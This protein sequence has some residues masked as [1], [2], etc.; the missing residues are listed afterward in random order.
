MKLYFTLTN[1]V[2]NSE[3]HLNMLRL[4]LKSARENT[5]LDL[6]A[7]YDGEIGDNSYNIFKENGVNVILCKC[8]FTDKLKKYYANSR[9]E[10]LLNSVERMLGCFM[11]FDIALYE[12]DDDVVLY[13]DIDTM[14]LKDIPKEAFNVKTLAAAPE[15]DKNFDIIKGNKYFSAGIMM[16][17]IPELTKRREKLFEM[18]DNNIQ[19][20][21]ECWDQGFFNELYKDDF[22]PL[23]LEYNWKPYW[24]IND[25]AIIIHIHGLKLGSMTITEFNLAGGLQNRDKEAVTGLVYY[26]L[27]A[28]RILG[29]NKDK[30]IAQYTKFLTLAQRFNNKKQWLISSF[31]FYLIYKLTANSKI[32]VKIHNTAKKKLL[33]RNLIIEDMNVL[34]D[35]NGIWKYTQTK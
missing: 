22:E 24:G 7:L 35:D 34:F 1:G 9:F 3:V 23:S 4:C 17:N 33:K 30:D 25:K 15:F 13:S 5:S 16:L 31:I 2:N 29:L 8:S 12:K 10:G 6:Y 27:T 18:L 19:P 11:K 20:Y 32:F 21:Q 28:Y 14:F 26:S